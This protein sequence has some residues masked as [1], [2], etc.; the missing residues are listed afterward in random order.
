[1]GEYPKSMTEIEES[2]PDSPSTLIALNNESS[3]PVTRIPISV[4]MARS[5][6][7][8][9]QEHPIPA[10]PLTQSAPIQH[11][12]SRSDESLVLSQSIGEISPDPSESLVASESFPIEAVTSD[13][14]LVTTVLDEEVVTDRLK[15][16]DDSEA[17]EEAVGLTGIS[18]STKPEPAGGE[19]VTRELI[20]EGSEPEPWH[21]CLR[22][23]N[24]IYRVLWTIF[25]L[26]LLCAAWYLGTFRLFNGVWWG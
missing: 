15:V 2:S 26:E 4:L 3:N 12:S 9:P 1:M 10:N 14:E 6:R 16:D 24:R 5:Q 21:H 8:P 17:E 7:S 22:K 19:L 18:T 23:G 20:W 11:T 25:V 13:G